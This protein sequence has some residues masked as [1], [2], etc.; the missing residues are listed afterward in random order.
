MKVT[1]NCMWI[2]N[3]RQYWWWSNI[4]WKRWLVNTSWWWQSWNIFW[5]CRKWRIQFWKFS[6][7]KLR[8]KKC[9]NVWCSSYTNSKLHECM[10]YDYPIA[11]WY[12]D[13]DVVYLRYIRYIWGITQNIE[14]K[15]TLLCL[16]HR[17]TNGLNAI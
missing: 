8:R 12:Q 1:M 17:K 5:C 3:K 14:N 6:F 15:K 13:I 10:H 16:Q 4:G 2:S 11:E 9:M 7:S